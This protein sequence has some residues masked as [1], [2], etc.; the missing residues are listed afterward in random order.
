MDPLCWIIGV[1]DNGLSSLSATARQH[2]AEA[3]TVIGNPRLLALTREAIATT[4]RQIPLLHPEEAGD[5]VNEAW[6]EDHGVVVLASGDP[7]YHGLGSLLVKRLPVH[8]VR[9]ESNLSYLQI[10]LARLGLP[11]EA[12]ARVSVHR[13]DDGPWQPGIGR[14]HPLYPLARVL[15]SHDVIAVLTSPANDPGRIA[16]MLLAEGLEEKFKISVCE[17]LCRQDEVITLRCPPQQVVDKNWANPN[18][19]VLQRVTP[20]PANPLFGQPESQFH[21]GDGRILVTR[22][23]IRAAAIGQMALTGGET[24][25]DI[26][27]GAGSV[28]LE[29]ARLCPQGW[30]WAMEKRAEAIRQM[31]ANRRRMAILNITLLHSKAPAGLDAI[32][33]PDVVFIGGSCGNLDELICLSMSRLRLHGRLVLNFVTLENLAVAMT[34]LNALSAHWEAVQIHAARTSILKG[35][36]RLEGAAPVWIVTSQRMPS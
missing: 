19:V 36:N 22:R 17:H 26:G 11:S 25:W 29:A 2:L 12:A 10:A 8:R 34:T 1:L 20:M 33:D 32:P 7:L 30:V 6:E 21:H 9:V 5:L 28:A 27:A 3:Q 35:M 23:E 24:V 14:Q 18:V 4:A 31:E 15:S 16:R 13:G